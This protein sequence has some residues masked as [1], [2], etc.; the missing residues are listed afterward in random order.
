MRVGSI[1]P[2]MPLALISVV[3]TNSA[4]VIT[5]KLNKSTTIDVADELLEFELD[6]NT[7]MTLAQ[8]FERHG[9]QYVIDSQNHPELMDA[10]FQSW[11][12]KV[13]QSFSSLPD[14][15]LSSTRV[16][17]FGNAKEGN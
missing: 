1:F 12:D 10:I 7:A 14:S 17:R 6:R 16:V 5:P 4:R 15:T 11:G 8:L 3:L 9:S 13:E 2:E